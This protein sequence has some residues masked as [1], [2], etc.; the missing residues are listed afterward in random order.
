[1][2]LPLY[3]AT[4][5]NTKNVFILPGLIV[6][7]GKNICNYKVRISTIKTMTIFPAAQHHL[8]KRLPE[9]VYQT[10]KQTWL[11]AQRK[12]VQCKVKT[13]KSVQ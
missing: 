11:P 6:V 13:V 4:Q 1:M 5:T 10:V 8:V 9:V 2:S 3:A 7:T 12:A